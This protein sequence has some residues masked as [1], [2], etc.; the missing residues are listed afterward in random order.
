MASKLINTNLDFNNVSTIDNLPNAVTPQQPVTLAQLE[1][2]VEGLSWKDSVRFAATA[3]IN[4]ASP[5]SSFDGGTAAL[6][7]RLLLPNQTA[8]EENGLFIFNGATSPLT[9]SPDASTANELEQAIVT[10][11][12]GSTYAGTTWRQ[13]SV[14]FVLGT[15][16][17][18]WVNFGVVAP[19]ASETASG[20]AEIAT[21]AEVN[22]G[23]DD[24]RIVTPL[25]LASW[26]SL[27]KKY[28]A[29]FGDGSSTSY[30][31][32]HNFNSQDV[33]VFVRLANST[34][35]EVVVETEITS[36]NAVTI[37]TNTAPA[38]NAYRVTV[39]GG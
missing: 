26:S 35:D 8:T 24:L 14:N 32:N 38:L 29:T 21:Q 36:V 2:A 31:I 3:N 33:I 11:E 19:P 30:T 7:D 15:D 4:L 13:N 10:V 12:E 22:A 5:G 6:N 18:V 25:K 39:L 9:R 1:S 28:S 16:P 20:I 27:V 37:K 23:S 17:I 34:F